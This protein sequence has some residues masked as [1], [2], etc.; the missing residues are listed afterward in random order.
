VSVGVLLIG[1]RTSIGDEFRLEIELPN[2]NRLPLKLQSRLSIRR[3]W[4]R[5]EVSKSVEVSMQ[6]LDLE[7]HRSSNGCRRS[8]AQ[9]LAIRRTPSIY[10]SKR[11]KAGVANVNS[12]RDADGGDVERVTL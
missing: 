8:P 10:I 3:H 6:E 2:K 7:D 1:K 12:V 9:R 4:Y 5:R 11:A